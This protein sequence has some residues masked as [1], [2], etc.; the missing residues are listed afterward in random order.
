MRFDRRNP[1][2]LTYTCRNVGHFS[3]LLVGSTI[4]ETIMKLST[5]ALAGAFA[6]SS[7]MALAQ[8]GGAGGSAGGASS[9]GGMSGSSG[10]SGSTP[11]GSTRAAPAGSTPGATTGMGAGGTTGPGGTSTNP[12]GNSLITPRQADRPWVR[13]DQVRP[14]ADSRQA[15]RARSK[16]PPCAGLFHGSVA[17]GIAK[18]LPADADVRLRTLPQTLAG[19][20]YRHPSMSRC[21]RDLRDS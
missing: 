21:G 7:S 4:R 10:M 19:A 13:T 15:F 12:S 8:A 3:W 6:L 14:P 5:L 1:A 2:H 11:G 18:S 9:S 17:A 16:A 20:R